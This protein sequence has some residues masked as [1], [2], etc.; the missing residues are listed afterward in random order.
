VFHRFRQAKFLDGGLILGSSQFTLLPQLPPKLLLNLKEVKVDSKTSNWLYFSKYYRAFH[1]FGQ[2]KFPN[3]GL[4]LGSSQ[5]SVLPQLPPKMMLSL[6][7]RGQNLLKNKLENTV[8]IISPCSS[9]FVTHS[10]LFL[11]R[12]QNAFNMLSQT[13]HG[14]ETGGKFDL[15]VEH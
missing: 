15:Q 4:V 7:K 10:V 1:I 13:L 5:F 8:M 14:P 9:K 12:F 6:I 11:L 2:A 3:D